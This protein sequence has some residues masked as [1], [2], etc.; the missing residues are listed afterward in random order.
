MITNVGNVKNQSACI[1]RSIFNESVT[2]D[3]SIE[4]VEEEFCPAPVRAGGGEDGAELEEDI[5][6]H[7]VDPEHEGGESV[8]SEVAER[9]A[10]DR[11]GTKQAADMGAEIVTGQAEVA[12]QVVEHKPQ[13]DLNK[14][15]VSVSK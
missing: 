14:V 11:V 3:L 9:Q 5:C 6:C 8:K 15:K 12:N 13:C 10:A 7:G 1:G 4:T 2:A